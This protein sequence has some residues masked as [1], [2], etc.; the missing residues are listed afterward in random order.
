[1]KSFEALFSREGKWWMV[2]I[3]ALDGLTQ[4]RRLA[5]VD[6]MVRE[7]IA[8][9]LDLALDEITVTVKVES[10]GALN[11]VAEIVDSI[12]AE[13]E[14]AHALE[15]QVNE[16]SER[17]AKALTAEAV[18]FHDVGV[19]LGVSHQRAHQLVSR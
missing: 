5:D 17:L 19:I 11:N 15:Q 2:A 1:M 9:S 12:K 7:F 18:P 14:Q 13:R 8:V 3:P 6:Q 10:V 4:A 16:E